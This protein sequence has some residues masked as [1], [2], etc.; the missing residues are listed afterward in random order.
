MSILIIA[1]ERPTESEPWHVRATVD[2]VE[3]TARVV[4]NADASCVFIEQHFS[5]LLADRSR[6]E[7]GTP[8]EYR[9]AIQELVRAVIR[10]KSVPLPADLAKLSLP[11]KPWWRFWDQ[12]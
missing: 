9:N 1:V 4:V 11:H 7:R 5:D 8:A 3:T 10:G 6:Q 12:A 2:G